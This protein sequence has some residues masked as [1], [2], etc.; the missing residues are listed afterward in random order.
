MLPLW[1]QLWVLTH[2]PDYSLSL[3]AATVWQLS[4]GWAQFLQDVQAD[5]SNPKASVS[6]LWRRELRGLMRLS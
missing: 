4:L 6:H 3:S 1:P 2:V 5:S